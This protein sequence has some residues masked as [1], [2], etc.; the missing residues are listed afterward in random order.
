MLKS[1]LVKAE[2]LIQLFTQV[3]VEKYRLLN[4]LKCALRVRLRIDVKSSC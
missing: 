1:A 3:K 2:V 4:V